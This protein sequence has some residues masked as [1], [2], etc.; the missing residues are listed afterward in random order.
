M[1]APHADRFLWVSAITR[2]AFLVL[3]IVAIVLLVRYLS[4]RYPAGG[5]FHSHGAV[6]PPGA[7]QATG[8]MQ[9]LEE[10]F[11]RGEIDE[12]EFKR[13]KEALRS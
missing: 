4:H 9:I 8:A 6:L 2:L 7:Q 1:Y 5:H 10:R 12:D 3:I 13:R 11:A